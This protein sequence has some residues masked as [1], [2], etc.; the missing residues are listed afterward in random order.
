MLINKLKEVMTEYLPIYD[1]YGVVRLT[2]NQK[3]NLN[4]LIGVELKQLI[5]NELKDHSFYIE[6]RTGAGKLA[7]VPWIGIHNKTI[8]S[9]AKTGVYISLLFHVDG[10]GISMSIQHGTEHISTSKIIEVVEKIKKALPA[11]PTLFN[12]Q[13]LSLRPFPLPNR[14][15]NSENRPRKYEFANIVGKSYSIDK[16]NETFIKDLRILCSIYNKLVSR[17]NNQL[18]LEEEVYQAQKIGMEIDQN[19][20]QPPGIRKDPL[21]QNIKMGVLPQRERKQGLLAL[22]NADWRCEVDS[23]HETF[24]KD[25]GKPYMEKHHLIPMEYYFNFDNNVDHHYNIY[26]LCPNCHRKI[27]LGLNE[28]KK[29]MIIQLYDKRHIYYTGLYNMNIKKLLNMYGV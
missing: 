18:I 10:K 8:N 25:D 12:T 19:D 21:E 24:I 11:F 5:S 1:D 26:S 4:K 23:S 27:H 20:H 28:D 15:A 22:I 6:G 17:F 3:V 29:K 2:E 9:D 16:L 14:L 13:T 7:D